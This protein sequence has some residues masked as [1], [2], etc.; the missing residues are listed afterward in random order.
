M[1]RGIAAADAVHAAAVIAAGIP[2]DRL[3]VQFRPMAAEQ[4]AA[5][6]DVC[7]RGESENVKMDKE[8][9]NGAKTV[10]ALNFKNGCEFKR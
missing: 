10:S 3:S 5:A 6:A 1:R 8:S 4:A 9:G 7:L 2:A